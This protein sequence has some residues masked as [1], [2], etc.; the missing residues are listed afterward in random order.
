MGKTITTMTIS[1]GGAWHLK[2]V[3][4]KALEHIEQQPYGSKVMEA[5]AYLAAIEQFANMPEESLLQDPQTAFTTLIWHTPAEISQIP[6]RMDILCEL[7]NHSSDFPQDSTSGL[8]AVYTFFKGGDKLDNEAPIDKIIP[9]GASENERLLG[10]LLGSDLE[11]Y[12]YYAPQSGF[13]KLSADKNGYGIRQQVP[14]RNIARWAFL[15]SDYSGLCG[16]GGF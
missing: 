14:L 3:P 2:G 1:T 15:P 11:E 13:Y 8:Y 4:Q 12:S 9:D 5:L 7:Q 6:S 16:E 10:S